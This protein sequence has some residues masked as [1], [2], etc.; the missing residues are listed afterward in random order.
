MTYHTNNSYP[1]PIVTGLRLLARSR[2]FDYFTDGDRVFSYGK[3][4]RDTRTTG[5]GD[6]CFWLRHMK[7]APSG[8]VLV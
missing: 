8:V 7:T 5:F 3:I 4:E 1:D 2:N 6:M